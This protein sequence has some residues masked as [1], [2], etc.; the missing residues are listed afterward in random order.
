MQLLRRFIYLAAFAILELQKRLPIVIILF[1]R[2]CWARFFPFKELLWFIF[3]IE[4]LLLVPISSPHSL[5]IVLKL[6][7][8]IF[9]SPNI[10]TIRSNLKVFVLIFRRLWPFMTTF[11]DSSINEMM[12]WSSFCGSVLKTF[13]LAWCPCEVVSL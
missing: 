8:L 12:L 9:W 3:I 1:I 6:F 4:P 2:T 11:G 13:V 10:V 7:A 5:L